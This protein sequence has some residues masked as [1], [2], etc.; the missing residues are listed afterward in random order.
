MR[1]S[2]YKQQSDLVIQNLKAIVIVAED[3]LSATTVKPSSSVAKK[4]KL[5]LL[6]GMCRKATSLVVLY[7]ARQFEGIEEIG[8]S[9]F[10]GYVDLENLQNDPKNYP[11]YLLAC[12]ERQKVIFLNAHERQSGDLFSAEV[13]QKLGDAFG[14]PISKYKS[15][16]ESLIQRICEKLP[17]KYVEVSKKGR[18]PKPRN[19]LEQKAKWAG[20]E[21][22]YN[23]FYRLMSPHSHHDISSLIL[24]VM[25]PSAEFEWPPKKGKV[26]SFNALYV[27][28]VSIKMSTIRIA[29]SFKRYNGPLKARLAELDPKFE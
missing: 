2:Q 5:V 29:K 16:Q 6:H 9:I 20:L 3:F 14:Y 10:E 24:Y 21:S 26:P 23:G 11:S 17:K 4:L 12:S 8:R 19:F 13:I 7:E 22:D 1:V 25:G 27:A 28:F 15:E 18:P